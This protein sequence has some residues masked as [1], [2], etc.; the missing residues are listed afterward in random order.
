MAAPFV[1]GAAAPDLIIAAATGGVCLAMAATLW[2][3]S[4]RRKADTRIA[5]FRER[6]RRLEGMADATQSSAEAFDSAMLT[7]E[8]GSVTLAW[9][10]DSLALCAGILGLG[11]TAAS[12]QPSAVIDALVGAGA[13]YARRLTALFETGEPCAFQ[14][15]GAEGFVAVDGRA[16]GACVWLRLQPQIAGDV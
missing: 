1:M 5:E 10:G 12:A 16:A 14:A 2:A 11:E 4:V 15:R 6:I 9:G 3:V 13:D 7:I 8:D